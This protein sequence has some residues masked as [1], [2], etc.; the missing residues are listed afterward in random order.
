MDST[1][2]HISLFDPKLFILSENY[3]KNLLGVERKLEI[4]SKLALECKKQETP[5]EAYFFF[6]VYTIIFLTNLKL[7]FEVVI[8]ELCQ[9]EWLQK[10]LPFVK[11]LWLMSFAYIVASQAITQHKHMHT[12]TRAYT[13]RIIQQIC[14][15]ATNGYCIMTK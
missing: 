8:F 12:R 3:T 10:W 13:W 2:H 15:S 9:P 1:Q 6:I 7:I 14:L 4:N 11:I 5:F